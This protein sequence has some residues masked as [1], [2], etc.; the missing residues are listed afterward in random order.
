MALSFRFLSKAQYPKLAD[1]AGLLLPFPD[2][3]VTN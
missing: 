3:N 1:A 2:G